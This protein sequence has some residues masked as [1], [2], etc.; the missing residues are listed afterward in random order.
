MHHQSQ[1]GCLGIFIGITQ[2]QKG[3]LV[4]VPTVICGLLYPPNVHHFEG[5]GTGIRPS[6]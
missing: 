2:H 1:N 3:Y 6:S 4:Y 5:G